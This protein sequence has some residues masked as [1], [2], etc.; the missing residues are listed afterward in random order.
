MVGM[1]RGLKRFEQ[2]KRLKPFTG[3]SVGVAAALVAVCG[4]SAG[5]AH[6]GAAHGGVGDPVGR[7]GVGIEPVLASRGGLG[8]GGAPV[9]PPVPGA[10]ADLAYH[11]H[12]SLWAGR[13]G[14][15]VE[16]SNHGPAA[17]PD[18]TVRLRFSAPLAGAEQLPP[19]CLRGSPETVLCS[20]GAMR[21]AGAGRPIALDLRVA[22]SPA[23][24]VVNINTSWSGGAGDRNPDNNTHRV[25]APATGDKYAY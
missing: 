16:P 6:G 14:V 9:A 21:A 22:G 23:E 25:L 5:V 15:W 20:T 17:V 4:P 8:A 24:V 19:G 13:V 12:V 7:M 18:T 10:E 3:V 2:F 11:G 1:R